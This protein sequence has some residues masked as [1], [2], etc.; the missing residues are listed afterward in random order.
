MIGL[1]IIFRVKWKAIE[2]FKLKKDELTLL[3]CNLHV[4]KCTHLKCAVG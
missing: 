4:I 2:C 3:R 1:R